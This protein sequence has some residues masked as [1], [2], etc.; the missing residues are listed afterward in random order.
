M[1]DLQFWDPAPSFFDSFTNFLNAWESGGYRS[2]YVHDP[3]APETKA[4][5]IFWTEWNK[6][7]KKQQ[8]PRAGN[9]M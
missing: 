5:R 7:P 2:D 9:S 1:A 4:Y 3:L 6:I 8:V